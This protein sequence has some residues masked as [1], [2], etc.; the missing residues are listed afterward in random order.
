MLNLLHIFILIIDAYKWLLALENKSLRS[1]IRFFLLS[2]VQGKRFDWWIISLGS[3]SSCLYYNYCYRNVF[4]HYQQWRLEIIRKICLRVIKVIFVFYVWINVR[5]RQLFACLQ[6]LW[7]IITWYIVHRQWC[8]I[9]GA[10]E[11][12]LK[13]KWLTRKLLTNIWEAT[14]FNIVINEYKKCDLLLNK[15]ISFSLNYIDFFL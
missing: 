6:D 7:I 2:T 9:E 13:L 12:D 5:Y 11:Q 8:L 1:Q 4:V 14:N 15:R 10:L 3:T